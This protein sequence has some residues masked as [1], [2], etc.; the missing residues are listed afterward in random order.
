M[1]NK[2]LRWQSKGGSGELL[3]VRP[4]AVMREAADVGDGNL[5]IVRLI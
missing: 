1:S 2:L 3:P 4:V 5:K